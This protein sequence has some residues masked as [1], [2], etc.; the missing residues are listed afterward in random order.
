MC[1]LIA[2]LKTSDRPLD[3]RLI[4]VMT[5]TMEHR[6]PDDFG[7]CF[8]G[9]EGPILW[10]NAHNAPQFAEKGVAMGHRR[11][12]VFDLTEVGRQPF[13]SP[14]KRFT[15]VF[16]GEIYNYVE[17]REELIQ[18][19]FH[20]ST[21]CDTE[22]LIAAFERWGTECFNRLNGCWGVVIWDDLTK[23]LVA[24]RDRLGEKPLLFTQ[25]DGDWIFASEAKVL[26][27]HPKIKARPNEELLADFIATGP[28]P[29]GENTYFSDIHSIEPGTFLTVRDGNVS[30]TRYYDLTATSL[31]R[32]TDDASAVQ[33]FNELLTDACRL[34]LRGDIRVGAMLSGGLDSTS[35]IASIAKLL[36]SRPGDTRMVGDTLEAFTA[37]FTGLREMADESENVD[38]LCRLIEINAHKTFPAE[39]DDIEERLCD[40]AWNME[41]PFFSPATITY[42]A[43]MKLVR[44]TDVQIVLDGLGGDELFAGFEWYIPLAVRDSLR[45]FRLWEA[46]SNVN[47][48]HRKLGKKRLEIIKDAL[49]DKDASRVSLG[50]FQSRFKDPVRPTVEGNNCLDRALKRDVLHY[51]TPQWLTL[52]DRIS[53]ANSVV[54]RSPLLDHR[55]VDFAF[56]L[57]NDLKIRNGETKYIMREAKRNVLPDSI[58]NQYK[59]GYLNGPRRHWLNGPLKNYALSIL[60]A[61]KSKLSGAI[62]QPDALRDLV[63]G[64]FKSKR[65]DGGL[66]WRIVSA[67]A[68]LRAYS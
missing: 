53:M 24:G 29:T 62:L 52:S 5:H 48:T 18:H 32:R 41:A 51:S 56:S 67:E 45:G 9:K 42:D 38:E 55:V 17:L 23:T 35:V 37:S 28:I 22:V 34:R 43:L 50:L 61:K 25:V 63:D 15:M 40:A 1:G 66:M 12:S 59:K 60:D 13:L 47:G 4:E 11:L 14:S 19:G 64:F 68:F 58:V 7:M 16:N 20:F 6:G 10:R 39:Q 54:C 46:M 30:K 31:I 57:K 3:P 21:D 65:G 44:S 49:R 2:Y 27:K 36:S 8:V 26:L 33:E